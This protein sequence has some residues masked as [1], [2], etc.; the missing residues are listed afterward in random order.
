MSWNRRPEEEEDED[1]IEVGSLPDEDTASGVQG[2]EPPLEINGYQLI[3]E[4]Q[5]GGQAAVFLAV[6]KSTGRRVA[7]KI[8]FGGPY[9][10]E[11]DRERMNQEVRILAA[12]DH[13][14]IV[15]VIDRGET[16]D[17]SLYFVMN[18]VDGRPLHEFLRDF[19]RD[20]NEALTR[21]DI[22][23][24]LKLFRR[25][26]EAVNAAHLR[27]IVHRDLKPANIIIDS[28]GEPHIL[29]FGLAHAPVAD[30]GA[31]NASTT[32]LSEFVGSLEWASPEQARGNA[33]Q[34]D[35]RTDVYALGV[36]LFQ[37]ITGEF[38]YEVRD[39][40][41]HVLDTI[42]SVRPQPPS[43]VLARMGK[44]KGPDGPLCDAALDRIVL[45]ALAKSRDD[46]YQNAGELARAI[47]AYLDT[48][49]PAPTSVGMRTA[50]IASA[51]LAAALATAVLWQEFGRSSP[52]PPIA[53]RYDDGI[54]GYAQDGD[55]LVFVFEPTRFETARHDNGRLAHVR[56]IGAVTR[57]FVA[58][59]FNGWAKEDPE[60]RMNPVG[61]DR[62][63]LRKPGFMFSTRAEWPFKFH[64]NGEYWV[65]APDRARNRERV[66]TDSATFNLVLVPPRASHASQVSALR[67]FREQIDAVWPGQGANLVF[68]QSNRLHFSFANLTPGQRITDLDPLRGIPLV[69]LDI[70]EAKVTDLSPL[71]GMTT[72]EQLKVN[73]G[74]FAAFVG[75]AI[76]ALAERRFEDARREIDR[77]MVGLTNVPALERAR[78][79]L[80]TAVDHLQ[81]LIERPG[82]PPDKAPTFQGRIYALIMTPMNWYEAAD[83]AKRHG[84]HLATATTRAENEW[85]LNTFSMPPLGRTLWLGG[86]DEGTESFWRWITQEGWRFENWG[87]PEP[88]NEHGN[89]HALAMR[90]DGWWM[91]ANSY[92]LR[93]PFVIEWDRSDSIPPNP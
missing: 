90:P 69:S 6:Q 27:G 85:L 25:I 61:P 1:G 81:T 24:L 36:I 20:R 8:I 2:Q 52:S 70:T 66:V 19:R 28:Y 42:I 89:E 4:I 68:D 39:E 55:D 88:N 7:L 54:Y 17:G 79:A 11:A 12:L 78:A 72:L 26:C 49:K 73:D 33:N 46:R 92:A 38:P 13:P 59:A 48:P 16:A 31:P 44:L 65:G 23:E 84:G 14:N 43:R 91:D 34:V 21:A 60:W 77:A 35:T 86:T 80:Q 53:V 32:Q 40:L 63:E 56:E 57:V 5:R 47:S 87:H 22:A 67:A 75:S 10:A 50:I 58:G 83:F 3:E 74:T 41:R 93:L 37:M 76:Q 82:Q 18:Y 51:L 9:A 15:S 45:K 71:S 30:G 64:V 62:F 29:D